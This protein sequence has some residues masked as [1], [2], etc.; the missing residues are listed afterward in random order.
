[1]FK[2]SG[3]N[4]TH[5]YPYIGT[6]VGHYDCLSWVPTAYYEVAHVV[7]LGERRRRT[8][9]DGTCGCTLEH[10]VYTGSSYV[11]A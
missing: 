5:T 9:L 4:I 8:L 6:M 1:M 10:E 3:R 2:I 7:L 11:N